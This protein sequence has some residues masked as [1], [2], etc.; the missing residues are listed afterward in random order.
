[1]ESP[2][3]IYVHIKEEPHPSLTFS[4]VKEKN[5]ENIKYIRADL[6]TL[7]IADIEKIHVFIDAVKKNKTG[8]FT[9]TR[10]SPE[11]YE[12]VLRRF[13]EQKEKK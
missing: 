12:D 1:M 11:Q 4:E 2:G 9:F 6:A 5:C 10:L 7:T 13:N 3:V 8:A